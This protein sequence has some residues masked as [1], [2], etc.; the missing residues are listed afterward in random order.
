MRMSNWLNSLRDRRGVSA[1]EF[2]LCLPIC[3]MVT[4][5]L[6]EMARA[7]I[8]NLALHK[9]LEAGVRFAAQSALPLSGTALASAENLV[10][11]GT[12]DSSAPFL[13]DHWSDGTA[14]LAFTTR[15]FSTGGVAGQIIRV[16]ASVPYG[17]IFP[18]TLP[19]LDFREM[20]LSGAF[21]MVHVG[22]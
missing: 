17:P 11:R 15:A 19:L 7:W 22:N 13:L 16:E 4:V 9:G 5:G 6:S 14:R 8:Q 12:L 18:V 3:L 10:K 21:E 20:R 2:A 1:V